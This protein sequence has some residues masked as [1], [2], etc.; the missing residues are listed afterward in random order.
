MTPSN[1][2]QAKVDYFPKDQI[3]HKLSVDHILALL[4]I[5]LLAMFKNWHSGCAADI[6][7]VICSETY[8]NLSAEITY[9]AP[10][11]EQSHL[12]LQRS[13]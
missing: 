7:P 6:L 10:N 9:L 5:P 2:V 3:K 12:R 13:H 1:L 11:I 8:I 4:R